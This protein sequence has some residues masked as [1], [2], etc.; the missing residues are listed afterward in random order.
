M[1][2][3]MLGFL[4]I[5]WAAF[6]LPMRRSS[7]HR[8]V[9]DFERRMDLLA[10]TDNGTGRWIVTPQKGVPFMGSRAR[11]QARARERRRRVLVFLAECIG[12]SFL[13]GLVPP[14]R[15]MWYLSGGLVALLGV[16]VWMLLSIKQR[17]SEMDPSHRVRA[18]NA[19]PAR[20]IPAR[21]RHAGE[22]SGLTR[23][24]FNGLGTLAADDIV[25]IV[26]RRAS[27]A[28]PVRV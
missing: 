3:L 25:K 6:L 13:I 16:Y 12:F 2:W 11:A 14:L 26:V 8:S 18:V 23:E 10:D 28:E 22:A 7:P 24:V 17:M 4:G 15:P 5:I 27:A 1:S 19:V 21:V 9:E 20:P